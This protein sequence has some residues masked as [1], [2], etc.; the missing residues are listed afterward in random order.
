MH[1]IRSMGRNSMYHVPVEINEET[2]G[3]R[4]TIIKGGTEK[5]KVTVDVY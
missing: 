4:V 5:G 2:A 3:V 1:M